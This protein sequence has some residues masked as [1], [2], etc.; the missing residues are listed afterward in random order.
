VAWGASLSDV[1]VPGSSRAPP[2]PPPQPRKKKEKEKKKTPPPVRRFG[3]LD[4]SI[5]C[6]EAEPRV[7][8]T[9]PGVAWARRALPPC[10]WLRVPAGHSW[11]ATLLQ[12][13]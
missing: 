9:P 6:N 5:V 3:S 1:V 2:P 8:R 4:A 7:F 13:P 10:G 11:S 12:A